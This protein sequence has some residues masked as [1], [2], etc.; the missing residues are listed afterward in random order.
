MDLTKYFSS[1]HDSQYIL[2]YCP[3]QMYFKKM[4]LLKYGVVLE[5]FTNIHLLEYGV[6]LEAYFKRIDT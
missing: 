2:T 4:H 3:S 5:Y 1:Q 6:V